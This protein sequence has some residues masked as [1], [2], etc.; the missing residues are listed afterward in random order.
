MEKKINVDVCADIQTADL[1]RRTSINTM[2]TMID[3]HLK[4]AED[5]ITG[6]PLFE[7]LLTMAVEQW[8]DWEDLKQKMIREVEVPDSKEIATW[9]LEYATGMLKYEVGKAATVKWKVRIAEDVCKAV[10]D[11]QT[12]LAVL[13]EVQVNILDMYKGD[14]S[15]FLLKSPYY[16]S[17][18]KL[19]FGAESDF[20]LKKSEMIAGVDV[21]NGTSWNLSYVDHTLRVY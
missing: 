21:G 3:H 15:G 14:T 8:E 18:N 5:T 16:K 2:I 11:A 9:D 20:E 17:L 7:G 19:V 10:Q 1:M 13:R 4:D 6:T 12:R